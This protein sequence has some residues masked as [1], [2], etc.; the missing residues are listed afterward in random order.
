MDNNLVQ[1][2]DT[3][4]SS[5]QAV[6]DSQDSRYLEATRLYGPALNRLVRGYESEPARRQDL[7][8]DIHVALWQSFA[9]FDGLC[10]LRTWV[11]RVAHNTATK[12]MLRNKRI[13]LQEMHTLDEVAESASSH[14]EA[15]FVAETDS[16]QR[17]FNL[18]EQLK[19][20]DRQVILLYLEEFD[21]QSIG[22]VMGLSPENIATKIH[23]IKKLLTA[24]FNAGDKS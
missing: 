9:Q 1:T 12:H 21:A 14:D 16:L 19:P 13:R 22:E 18:I 23:R 3:L 15:S 6:S 7:L 24:M 4:M 5:A 2:A 20:V 11:Y 17:M 8:Q 10:S